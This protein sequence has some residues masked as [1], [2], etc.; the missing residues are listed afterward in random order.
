MIFLM[1][2]LRLQAHRLA[3]KRRRRVK[4]LKIGDLAYC[5][6]PSGKG[7]KGKAQ[8]PYVV[9]KTVDQTVS[10]RT[11]AAVHGQHSK[12]FKKHISNVA[13]TVTVTD[14]S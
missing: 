10:L 13:R 7:F 5:M 3:A 12:M 11:T 6:E 4:S 9:Q 1:H 14:A 2:N 8:R